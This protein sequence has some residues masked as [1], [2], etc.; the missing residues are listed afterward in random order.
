M[1]PMNVWWVQRVKDVIAIT[2]SEDLAQKVKAL[3]AGGADRAIDRP[4]FDVER[5]EGSIAASLDLV[6][7]RSYLVRLF[8]T[9]EQASPMSAFLGKFL[10]VDSLD[11]ATATVEPREDGVKI[12]ADVKFSD[13]K[14]REF[15]DVVATYDLE[16]AP[17]ADGILRLLPAQDTAMVAQVRTPPRALLGAMLDVASKDDQ[18]LFASH[19]RKVGADRRA[20]GK[21]GYDNTE[22]FLDELAKQLGSTTAIA[23]ARIPAVFDKAKYDTWY[24]NEDPVPLPSVALI[25]KIR[26]GARQEDVDEFLSDRAGALGMGAPQ[27]VKS[28]NGIEYSRLRF[29]VK[30]ADLELVEPGFL[31]HD[32][33]F[34]VCTREEYLLRIL[35]VMGG[36]GASSITSSPEFRAAMGSL[37]SSATVAI[38]A[39]GETLRALLWDRRNPHVRETHDEALHERSFRAQRIAEAGR[40]NGN[41]PLTMDKDFQ[42]RIQA[43]V[44]EE[45]KRFRTEGYAQFI[46]EYRAELDHM[47]RI[48]AF[49]AVLSAHRSES[50]IDVGARLVLTP[51]KASGE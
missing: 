41:R 13:A 4:G 40:A 17:V 34:I 12:R 48:A 37:P 5:P 1:G 30:P 8:S 16:P 38:Y 39:N 7:I 11:R 14:L 19:V 26:D 27:R 31:V 21:E 22:Q 49:G 44:T 32:G 50:F 46:A 9:G 6:G 29:D 36:R 15:R 23:V 3:G 18:Q 42:T 25:V 28:P 45:M 43:D 35:D 2:N 24:L 51:S 10:A 20:A 33:Y 47:K